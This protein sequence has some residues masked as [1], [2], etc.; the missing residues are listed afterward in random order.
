[1]ETVTISKAE[2]QKL[3][4]ESAVDTELVA[5]IKMALEDAKHGRIKEWKG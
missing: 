1:M 3:K 4:Q 5:K 2:Y